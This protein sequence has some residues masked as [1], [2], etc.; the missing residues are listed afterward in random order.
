MCLV[1][2]VTQLETCSF[3]I[4][5]MVAGV[6]KPLKGSRF[7]G[8]AELC[9]VKV[10]IQRSPHGNQKQKLQIQCN[11][12]SKRDKPESHENHPDRQSQVEK[13]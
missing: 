7:V 4:N 12:R 3:E 9:S 2:C 6:V 1:G 8:L 13:K 5:N 11:R 10:Y